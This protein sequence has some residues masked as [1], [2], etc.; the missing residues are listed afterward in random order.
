MQKCFCRLYVLILKVAGNL[1]LILNL[2]SSDQ[3][4]PFFSTGHGAHTTNKCSTIK[5]ANHESACSIK[6]IKLD[7]WY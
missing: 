5:I 4:K 1:Y 3:L 6:N 2:P 7:M